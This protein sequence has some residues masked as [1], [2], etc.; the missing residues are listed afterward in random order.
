VET[1]KPRESAIPREVVIATRN[2]GKLRE[3][4][5]ILSPLHLK[6]LSLKDF[7]DLPEVEEDGTTFAENAGKK[8]R[9]IAR[10]TGRLTI[11]D[12]SGIAVYAL[13]GQPGVLSA[14]YAGENATDRERYQKLLD[15]MAEIQEGKRQATFV[16]VLA[17]AF[18]KGKMQIVEGECR[19]WI[20]FAPRG[21]HGFGYDPIF[22]VPEFAKTMAE[23]EPEVKNRISHRARAL[24]KL[25]LILPKFLS[26]C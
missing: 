4:E 5:A 17:V 8:A 9:A 2:P 22:F 16:C 19:G 13:G 11:A 6:L 26:S 25:K 24:E 18:P 15:E 21:K 12:D 14:R 1:L 7:P 10:L 3:I 23:L 20:T